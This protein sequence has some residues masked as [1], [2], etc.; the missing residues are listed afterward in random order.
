MPSPQIVLDANILARALV[1][2]IF[3]D[4]GLAQIFRIRW[5]DVI[6]TET[7]RTYVTKIGLT[8]A[9]ANALLVEMDKVFPRA[10]IIGYEAREASMTNDPKDRHITAAA[11]H[12]GA[13]IVT[14]NLRHF[15]R[16]D[17]APFSIRAIHPDIYL[18]AVYP[19][20]PN[21]LVDIVRQ[22]A[23]QRRGRLSLDDYLDRLG[24]SLPRFVA[25]ARAHLQEEGIL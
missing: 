6:L 14:Y 17:L 12:I 1:R 19:E 20:H 13:D 11:A 7:H 4:A 2:D 23:L 9:D 22:Q 3:L 8:E 24:H 10:R 5:T 18:T 25:I 15:R 16:V 21:T